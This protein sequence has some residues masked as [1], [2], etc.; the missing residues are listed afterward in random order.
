M[1]HTIHKGLATKLCSVVLVGAGGTG[2]QMLSG[3]ARMHMGL[4][5]LGHP[6]LKVTVYDPDSISIS[7]VGRQL[8]ALSDVG[9]NKAIVLVNRLNQYY[10]MDWNAVPEKYTGEFQMNHDL[11]ITCVDTKA[12]RATIH[13]AFADSCGYSPVYWLDMGNGLS[14]G[15]IVLGEPIRSNTPGKRKS[16]YNPLRLP[17]MTELF[18]SLLDGSPEDEDTPTCSLAEALERQDLMVCQ[19]IAT[20]ALHMLWR[21][22][23]SGGVD[24]SVQFVNLMSGRVSPLYVDT[25]A[26]K[27]FGVKR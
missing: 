5:S 11:Y 10:G 23:L 12:A 14:D 4:Q 17:T 18:P 21:L 13:R 9:H 25:K 26:W 19:S 22:F 24:F 20:F 16:G 7:N 15:Q 2:S 8:F 27:R 6:G 3:L 1:K